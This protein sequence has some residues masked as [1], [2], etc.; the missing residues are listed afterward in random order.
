M[1]T[2][3]NNLTVTDLAG[4]ERHLRPAGC[5]EEGAVDDAAD[6]DGVRRHRDDVG[7]HAHHVRRHAVPLH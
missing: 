5:L 1:V 6:L 3:Y 7:E 4:D 2:L